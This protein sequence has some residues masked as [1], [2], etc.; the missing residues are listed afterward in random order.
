MFKYITTAVLTMVLSVSLFGA[1]EPV[2]GA[3]ASAKAAVKAVK[4]DMK[5][6]CPKAAKD[7]KVAKDCAK[8][9]AAVKKCAKAVLPQCAKVVKADSNDMV[10]WYK[11]P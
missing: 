7:C 4:Q 10:T 6:C 2:V 9:C 11:D 8:A 1:K 3:K 5:K